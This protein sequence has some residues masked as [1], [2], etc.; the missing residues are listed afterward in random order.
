MWIVNLGFSQTLPD[1]RAKLS[2]ALPMRQ[3]IS[4]SIDAFDTIK[5]RYTKFLTFLM[6]LSS[7]L[8]VGE[9]SVPWLRTLVFLRLMVRSK[10]EHSDEN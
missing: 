7:I 5:P 1:S 3:L 6:Y 9:M 4:V 2:E 8:I 10:S